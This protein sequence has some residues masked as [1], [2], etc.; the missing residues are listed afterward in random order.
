M[1]FRK[2]LKAYKKCP[3]CLNKCLRQQ[4][5]C[6]ECGLIFARLEYASNK[7]AKRK[8]RHFDKDFVIYTT[9][10][11]SD[12]SWWKLLILS[13]LTGIVGG[14]HYYA[15]KYWKGGLMTAGFIYLIFCTVFNAQMVEALTSYYAYLPIGLLGISWIASLI[16]VA[17]KKYKVPVIVEVPQQELKEKRDEFFNDELLKETKKTEN[18]LQ[19]KKGNTKEEVS[20]EK[21]ENSKDS[22]SKSKQKRK[23]DDKTKEMSES[24]SSNGDAK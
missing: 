7:A 18:K 1:K 19:S 10:F 13:F 12:I 23:M 21:T 24:D 9:Q 8:I 14:H 6:E 4:E 15:G 22:K 5:T 17:C 20:E 2:K 11:P 3:R 16:Y